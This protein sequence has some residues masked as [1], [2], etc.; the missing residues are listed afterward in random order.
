[1]KLFKKHYDSPFGGITLGSD[2]DSLTGLQFDGQ[3]YSA[4]V[5]ANESE[6][7]GASVFAE[8]ARWLD[9]YFGGVVPDFTPPLA[10]IGSDFRRSVWK[11]LL[12]IPYGE[13]VTYGQIAKEVARM[14]GLK[15]MSA[16]AVG[17]AVGHN[18][19]SLIIPCHRVIGTS[20]NLTGYAGGLKLKAE[21]LAL[22]RAG[23]YK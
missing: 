15:A 2:G 9:I 23:K 7:G 6:S 8:A 10:V 14:S 21:L 16:Q 20:G 5:P 18:P 4:D 19:V 3:R 22:E 17:S 13:T 11:I 1:M 12:R